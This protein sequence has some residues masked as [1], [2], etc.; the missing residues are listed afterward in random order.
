MN[1]F[2]GAPVRKYQLK[3]GI[4]HANPRSDNLSHPLSLGSRTLADFL[5]FFGQILFDLQGWPKCIHQLLS[6]GYEDPTP[7]E[8]GPRK[9]WNL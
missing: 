4:I 1:I 6:E 9:W 5:T 3:S 2:P 8:I 7:L